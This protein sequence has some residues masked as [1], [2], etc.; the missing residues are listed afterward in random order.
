MAPTPQRVPSTQEESI[1]ALQESDVVP[2]RRNLTG[3][4][5]TVYA[6]YAVEDNDTS[7][8]VGVSPEYMTYASDTEKP[9]RADGGVEGD[10]EEAV[11][12]GSK[13][14]VGTVTPVATDADTSTVGSGASSDLVYTATSGEG[15][16]AEKV[17]P[18]EE[19]EPV[20]APKVETTEVK[21]PAAVPAEGAVGTS[22]V[23]AD[24]PVVKA[25]PKK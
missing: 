16:T 11:L 17:V 4:P 20:E 15:F 7:A 14:A 22:E 23:Q 5:T 10:L 13:F 3:E 25:A 8:Y 18:K 21:E 12:D 2:A 6:P 19:S 1:K 9:L 24:G